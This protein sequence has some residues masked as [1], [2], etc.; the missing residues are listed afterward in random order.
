[1]AKKKILHNREATE[2]LGYIIKL[3]VGSIIILGALIYLILVVKPN[4]DQIKE[5]VTL[6]IVYLM[7]YGTQRLREKK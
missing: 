4:Y 5:I 2:N 1:M 3:V 6:I 7:G